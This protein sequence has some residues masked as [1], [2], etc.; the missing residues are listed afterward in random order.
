[1]LIYYPESCKGSSLS[2]A[3]LV[4]PCLLLDGFNLF[5]VFEVCQVS[6]VPPLAGYHHLTA[7]LLILCCI[8]CLMVWLANTFYILY[9]V[10]GLCRMIHSAAVD[11]FCWFFLVFRI[12]ILFRNLLF[13]PLC[14]GFVQDRDPPTSALVAALLVSFNISSTA[15][16]ASPHSEIP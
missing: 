10:A 2:V 9:T 13:I 5:L 3:R 6:L 1:M 11:M 14:L 7:G 12:T 8:G 15:F 16:F 4:T